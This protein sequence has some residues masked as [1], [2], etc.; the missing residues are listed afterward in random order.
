MGVLGTAT[1]NISASVE[2]GGARVTSYLVTS[3]PGDITATF[4]PN[5]IK[6]ARVSGLTPGNLYSF[7]VIAI[8]SKGASPSSISP[9]PTLAP[10]IPKAPT[11]TRV[12]A[13]GTNTAQLMFTAP[14][15]DGGAPITSYIARSNP[16]GLQ[17]I[18]YQSA[19][20]TIDISN[21][22]HS[23]SYTFTL[24]AINDAGASPES[25]VSTSITT[26]TP[27]PPP[28]PAAA[29][30]SPS[31][32]PTPTP[33]PSPTPTPTPTPTLSTISVAA[34]AGVTAPVTGAT[35]VTTTTAG[36][37]YTGAV[38]WA[39]SGGALVGN[40]A[41]ATTYTATITLT[42]SAGYTLTGVTANFFS[43]TGAT[44]VTHS[45][46][47]GV[48]TAV[49]PATAKATQATLSITSLTT[50]TKAFPYSQTLSIATSGGSGTGDITFAIA[51]GGTASECALSN[52]T[53]TATITATTNGTCRIQ[54]TKAA[55][56][57]YDEITSAAATFIFNKAFQSIT[58]T[59]PL[60]MTFGGSNQ[61]VTPTASS[62]LTVT[63]TST[64]TGICTVAGFVITAV[65]SGTCSIT[66]SQA[67]NSNYLAA[68]DVVRTFGVSGPATAAALAITTEPQ[69][70]PSGSVLGTQPVIRIID[71]GGNTVT[72]STAN[73]VVS[74]SSG[75]G[76]LSGTTTVAAVSGVATF[77]NLVIT[78]TAGAYTLTFGA[79]GLTGVTATL[80][81]IEGPAAK[82]V[83]NRDSAG[84]QRRTAFTTQ[85]QITIQDA[86][87][88]RVTQSEVVV[89][90]T[91]SAGGT[92]VGTTTATA[93]AG[94]AT[95]NGLGVEG[96]VGTTYTITYTAEGL[97]VATATVTLTGTTCDGISFTCK[98]GDIGPG[99][100]TVF[101]V[102]STTFTQVGSTGSMCGT[103]C[104]YLEAAPTTSA[105]FAWTDNVYVWSGNTATGIGA[106]AQQTAIGTGYANTLA[107]VGQSNTP[108]MAATISQA[109]RGPNG[110]SDWFLPSKDE[111]NQIYAQKTIVGGIASWYYWSS[112]EGSFD[113]TRAWAQSLSNGLQQGEFFKSRSDYY[114]RPIR[115]F[116]LP[117]TTISAPAIA[118]VTAPVTGAT[119]VTTT[120]AGTG[121]TG[122]VSWSGS[123]ATFVANTRYTATITLTATSGYTLTGISANFFTV[124][125]ASSVTHSANSGVITAVFYMVGST[126]S[127][128]GK[129]F[130]V[131]ST[132]FDCG[133]TANRKKCTYLEAAPGT[134]FD[135]NQDPELVWAAATPPNLRTESV[136][137]GSAI[138]SGYQ[139]SLNIVNQGND[140]TTA[141][142]AAR[143]YTVT[144]GG[145]VFNDWFLPSLDELNELI[146]VRNTF[147]DLFTG[148]SSYW[149]STEDNST[150]GKAQRY[151]DQSQQNTNKG[152]ARFVRPV[153]SF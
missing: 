115:A 88:N 126:G 114:V 100:G 55:D 7:S 33:T 152:T 132:P 53:A 150:S 145:V 142:G 57:T 122:T 37:G 10:T 116:G 123:P 26:A 146:L 71:A 148:I 75:T 49:F 135:G 95:F 43:I 39:S 2:D 74:I 67:G 61:S 1:L 79:D 3:I 133:P 25:A 134:W 35:P 83:I 125:G 70:A 54:A 19:S 149:S 86:A 139:N 20:G 108:N 90:A 94:I 120:T 64:S 45:A 104:K 13:T 24:T 73:V 46:D 36:T 6:A 147:T 153:R 52:S 15:N 30:P 87:N 62:S 130:Y 81:L 60:P 121:Y 78:G 11:I 14:T 99:G 137:T 96:N 69:G 47:S 41:S 28:V 68:F 4:K 8:N 42:A 91:V 98:V 128:G 38:T 21:L 105:T 110:L 44:S 112:S 136:T 34:I 56:S 32:S 124:T 85:P 92:L 76:T 12:V 143:A 66:A 65:G 80:F 111:L 129:I 151:T 18:I 5:Q 84:T 9:K 23:T 113:T 40:F 27:P 58:F 107:I 48:I 138:G 31:P 93:S 106:T 119:P 16:G 51:S 127:G 29:A 131:A 17:T 102:A 118:G 103:N 97:T 22:I 59:T 77:T 63:L 89:T 72:T 144:V 140:V 117:P 109:Y 101:Y 50:N 82:V 141:A